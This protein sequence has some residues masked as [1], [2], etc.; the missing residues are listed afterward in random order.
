MSYKDITAG[1]KTAKPIAARLIKSSGKG[2]PGVE[3]SF[4]FLEPSTGGVERLSWVGWLSPLAKEYTMD[5]LVNV[6]DSNG[7][8]RLSAEGVFPKGFVNT[9][10]EVRLVVELEEAK[11]QDGNPKVDENGEV[12]VYPNIKYVNSLSGSA[13]AGC[14]PDIGKQILAE[15]G[16]KASFMSMAQ[17][18]GKKIKPPNHALQPNGQTAP[19]PSFDTNENIPF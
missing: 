9:D 5:T 19:P 12:R 13:Y 10:K 11:D 4:E 7:D 15:T 17:K 16:F 2:T 14:T 18:S 8:D 1:D 6:L 3:V